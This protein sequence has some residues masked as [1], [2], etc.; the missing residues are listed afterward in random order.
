MRPVSHTVIHPVP[1]SIERVFAVL[2]DPARIAQWLPGCGGV[3]SPVPLKKGVRFKARFGNRVT[4]FE[5]VD[6]AP[7]TAFG[8]VERGERDGW[9]TLF[10]LD[11]T[12]GS[13]ALTVRDVWAPRSVIAWLRGRLREKRQVH[14]QLE[15]I[16]ANVRKLLVA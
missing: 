15:A 12:A 14:S 3:E 2:T 11:E 6:F 4:E 8:L 13:T 10:R 1:A 16:L 9:K 5:V 7:P